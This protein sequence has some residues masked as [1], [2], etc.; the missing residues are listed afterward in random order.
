MGSENR[1]S[2]TYKT[3]HLNCFKNMLTFKFFFGSMNV[4]CEQTSGRR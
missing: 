4:I 3:H 2:E 1:R